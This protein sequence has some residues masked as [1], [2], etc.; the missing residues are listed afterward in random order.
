[1][2]TSL[3]R[4][5]RST[6][7]GAEQKETRCACCGTCCAAFGG[8]LNASR[9]DLER[10]QREGREDLLSRINRLG[11]IWMD[12]QTGQPEGTCPFLGR[13]GA[14]T[15]CRIHDTKPA[16]CRGYPTLAHGHRC[17]RRGFLKS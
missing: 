11:W 1:M 7:T 12:P 9:E 5:L 6:V 2:L 15:F 16:M 14:E 17:L 3:R 13:S 8:H 4:W 10:W